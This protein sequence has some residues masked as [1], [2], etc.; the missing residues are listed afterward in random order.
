MVQFD[1]LFA[2]LSGDGSLRC[3]AGRRHADDG[4]C[5]SFRNWQ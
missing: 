5:S 4:G 2:I 1:D 3:S